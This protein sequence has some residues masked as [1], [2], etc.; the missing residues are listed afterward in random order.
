MGKDKKIEK[1]DDSISGVSP[2]K[3]DNLADS[4]SGL[5]NSLD[6]LK[7]QIKEWKDN[8]KKVEDLNILDKEIGNIDKQ[9]SQERKLESKEKSEWEISMK[10]EV[11]LAKHM[12]KITKW[13][14]SH[15]WQAN[16]WR[17]EAAKSLLDDLYSPD[18]NPIAN[19]LQKIIRFIL[20][21]EK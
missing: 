1:S 13:L 21:S 14:E 5:K 20:G 11:V 4:F 17:A 12:Q 16:E 10:Q 3:K 6:K 7:N 2:E 8:E 9:I 18:P 19:A 15:P